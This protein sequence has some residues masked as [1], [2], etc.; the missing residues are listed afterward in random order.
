M[1]NDREKRLY[2]TQN[3]LIKN[4]ARF[5]QVSNNEESKDFLRLTQNIFELTKQRLNEMNF[6]NI[7]ADFGMSKCFY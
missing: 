3:S 6:G 4:G 5:S 1:K 2:P 7:S